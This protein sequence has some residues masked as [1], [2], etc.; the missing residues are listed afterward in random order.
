MKAT[1]LL[2]AVTL[3]SAPLSADEVRHDPIA[4]W[5]NKHSHEVMQ[6]TLAMMLL[7]GDMDTVDQAGLTL[8]GMVA[9]TAA[10]EGL[11]MVISDPRPRDPEARDG[12]PSSH[13]A[14]AFALAHGLTGWRGSWGPAVY[15]FAAGVGWARVE[16]DHHSVE[17]VLAGAAVGMWIAGVSRR[18]DGFLF[19]A[20]A[21]MPETAFS[22]E[23]DLSSVAASPQAIM[24]LWEQCW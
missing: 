6:G 17:Q 1:S 9:A 18:S 14:A 21:D 20:G 12:M 2:I 19:H 16:E 10:A 7:W 24:L 4:Q 5:L 11:K 15:A 8:D 22:S 13:T 23:E 3:M